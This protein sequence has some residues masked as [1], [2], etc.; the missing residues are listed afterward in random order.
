MVARVCI[1]T[2]C[3][4]E[5]DH[6][7]D[8]MCKLCWDVRPLGGDLIP[9]TKADIR[10]YLDRCIQHWRIKRDEGDNLAPCYIDAF[11]SVRSTIFGEILP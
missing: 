10:A 9:F 7:R 4:M 3:G 2:R 6:F 11:Q 1:C 8:G 5:T